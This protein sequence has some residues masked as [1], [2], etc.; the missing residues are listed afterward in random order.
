MKIK[1]LY[2]T[3][4]KIT[5]TYQELNQ[6]KGLGYVLVPKKQELFSFFFVSIALEEIIKLLLRKQKKE[7]E[8]EKEIEIEKENQ[9][10]NVKKKQKNE[11]SKTNNILQEIHSKIK[12]KKEKKK[13]QERDQDQDQEKEKKKKKKFVKEQEEKNYKQQKQKWQQQTSKHQEDP[14]EPPFK[15]TLKNSGSQINYL[16][17]LIR[18][19][20]SLEKVPKV[21]NKILP[22]AHEE[23]G[24]ISKG[25]VSFQFFFLTGK[26]DIDQDKRVK[27]AQIFQD[28]NVEI[29]SL[30]S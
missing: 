16:S 29:N 17:K 15:I 18:K 9:K 4:S 20:G 22:N 2:F 1:N 26:E 14:R 10:E 12:N 21:L 7:I 5:K 13:D 6:F 28:Q 11:I 8:K 19:K 24:A 27:I 3:K 30:R 23:N 25:E